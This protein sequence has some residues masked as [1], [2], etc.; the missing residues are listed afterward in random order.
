MRC[1]LSKLLLNL[2]RTGGRQ[3]L[4]PQGFPLFPYRFARNDLESNGNKEMQHMVFAS[5]KI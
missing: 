2:G 1:W 3:E 4:L 5:A